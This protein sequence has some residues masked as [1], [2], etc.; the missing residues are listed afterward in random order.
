MF[1]YVGGLTQFI[2]DAYKCVQQILKVLKL[3][4]IQSVMKLFI[5][6]RNFAKKL[7]LCSELL[8]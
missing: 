8:S 1:M 3:F 6:Q 5:I 7:S 4:L 2:L